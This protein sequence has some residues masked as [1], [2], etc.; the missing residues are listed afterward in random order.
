MHAPTVPPAAFSCM[1]LAHNSIG[2]AAYVRSQL[3]LALRSATRGDNMN[4]ALARSVP[5][6]EYLSVIPY[7]LSVG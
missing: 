2:A 4:L 6:D 7:T 5:V 3:R 1:F